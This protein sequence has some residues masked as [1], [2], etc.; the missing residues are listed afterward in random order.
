MQMSRALALH[1]VLLAL[2]AGAALAADVPVPVN[3]TNFVRAETDLYFS[4]QAASIGEFQ[5]R[6]QMADIDHQDVVRMNRDTLYSTALFDLQAGPVT[7]TLPDTGKRFM[8]MQA[9]SQDHYTPAVVY[10]PGTF[11][12]TREQVGTRYV[13]MIVRTLANPEDP[14]DLAEVHALQ[15]R[16]AVQQAAKGAFEAPNWDSATR[17]RARNALKELGALGDG[18]WSFFGK[19][20]EVSQIDHLVGAAVGW[21]GNPPSAATYVG[22]YPTANDGNTVHQLTVQDVPVDGFWSISVYDKDGYYRKNALGAY[23][24]NNLTAKPNRDGSYTVQFGGCGP[25]TG[26]CLPITPG[27]NY[28]VRLYRPRPEVLDGRWQFPPA[29][30]VK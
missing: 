7:I 25:A 1:S 4:Q 26:N 12:F 11:T 27:W 14:R 29:T 30:P 15:D 17:D 18:S 5:H 20:G 28:T 21:G 22:V 13:Q 23:S 3:V 6:R 10:A 2:S 9:V 19:P 16:I 24:I 8:S